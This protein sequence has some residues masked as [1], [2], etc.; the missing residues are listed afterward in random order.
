MKKLLCAALCVLPGLILAVGVK[1]IFGP[2]VHADGSISACAG[3][4]EE[5]FHAGLLMIV[6]A[7]AWTVIPKGKRFAVDMVSLLVSI[8]AALLP[9][10]MKTCM[11]QTMR[12]NAVMRPAVLLIAAAGAILNACLF[13]GDVRTMKEK[14]HT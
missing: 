8:C 7:L 2:C 1:T 3:C 14:K 4:G 10:L 9:F 6:L 13:A 11:M 5:V 12:C